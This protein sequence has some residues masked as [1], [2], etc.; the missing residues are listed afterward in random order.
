MAEYLPHWRSLHFDAVVAIARGGMV[1]GLIASMGLSLPLHALS[2]S[3]ADRKVSW[4]TS[5]TPSIPSKILL[6]EDI[7]G[8]G[9]T[10]SDS[11]AF[12]QKLGHDVKVFTDRKSVVSGKSVSVRVDLGGR[13]I[14]KKKKKSN[15]VQ[16]KHKLKIKTNE[17]AQQ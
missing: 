16:L 8:R 15:N 2:Y 4:Y 12:L 9:T 3:R 17:Q 11:L 13:R 10:L 6:V 7:A 14:I 1:P 5:Q